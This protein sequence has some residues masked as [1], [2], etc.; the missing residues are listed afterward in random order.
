MVNSVAKEMDLIEHQYKPSPF[1]ETLN[2]KLSMFL[3]FSP[4]Q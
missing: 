2:Q 1:K 3:T 4:N